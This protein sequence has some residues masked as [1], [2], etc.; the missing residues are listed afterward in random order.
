MNMLKLLLFMGLAGFAGTLVRYGCVRLP[1]H[2]G[3]S[4]QF[5]G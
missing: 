1:D 4:D 2:E 5:K 3:V